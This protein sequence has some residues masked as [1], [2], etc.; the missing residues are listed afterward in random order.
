LIR[1]EGF[2]VAEVPITHRP[3][4]SGRSHYGLWDRLFTSCYDLLAVRWMQKRMV[5][6]RIEETANLVV[7]SPLS[8]LG[9]TSRPG[10]ANQPSDSSNRY[11][12]PATHRATDGVPAAA[13]INHPA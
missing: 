10:P 8:R 12:D 1:I 13:W 7:P 4:L 2:T 11:S 9:V 5:S 6:F 3:R